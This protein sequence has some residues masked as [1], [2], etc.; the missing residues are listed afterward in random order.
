MLRVKSE[1]DR[2]IR[3]SCH[4]SLEKWIYDSEMIANKNIMLYV[5]R[6]ESCILSVIKFISVEVVFSRHLEGYRI[7]EV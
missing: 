3:Y 7:G 6:I 1:G 2:K 5:F 4:A